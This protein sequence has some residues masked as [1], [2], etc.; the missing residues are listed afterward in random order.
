MI[1]IPDKSDSCKRTT[2]AKWQTESKL[3]KPQKYIC[4]YLYMERMNQALPPTL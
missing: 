4:G 2:D 1:F 3:F